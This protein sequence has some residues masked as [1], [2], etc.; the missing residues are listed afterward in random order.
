MIKRLEET[1]DEYFEKLSLSDKANEDNDLKAETEIS[2]REK[3]ESL[4]AR[5]EQ[6]Q[7]S[8]K[9]CEQASSGAICHTDSDARPL[10]K[11]GK[12]IVGYNTQ[13]AVDAKHHLVVCS[14]I[15]EAANDRNQLHS[16]SVLAKENLPLKD[17]ESEPL[18][19]IADAGY[20][21]AAEVAA[22]DTVNIES[23]VLF[24]TTSAE[25]N[26]YFSRGDFEYSKETDSMRCPNN[27]LLP[28][29]AD[30]KDSKSGTVYKVYGGNTKTCSGCSLKDKCTTSKWR[31]IR[32]NVDQAAADQC[33]QRTKQQPSIIAQR[34][35]IVEHPFGTLKHVFFPSGL[36]CIGKEMAEAET[37][38]G[39]LCYNIR[40]VLN[41]VDVVSLVSFI[42]GKR[43]LKVG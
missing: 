32:V 13:A 40:R 18:K 27:Q 42:T 24:Q 30:H 31:K 20:G 8:L 35:S 38:L 9:E 43:A 1:I 33:V 11:G 17:E 2:I 5:K 23:H 15:V 29:R 12:T 37:S 39:F 22:N 7:E 41:I 36:T 21:T 19:V 6:H 10:R 4:K 34:S 3:I 28:R 16:M 25:N 14:E 26:S